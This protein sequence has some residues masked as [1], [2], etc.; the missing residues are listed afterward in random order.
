MKCNNYQKLCWLKC[1]DRLSSAMP[2]SPNSNKAV[3]RRGLCQMKGWGSG[4]GR[5]DI[6]AN[7]ALKWRSTYIHT[8][9]YTVH[10]YLHL[11]SKFSTLFLHP[12]PSSSICIYILLLHAA[13]SYFSICICNPHLHLTSRVKFS[14]PN[15]RER[16][17]RH[18]A[19]SLSRSTGAGTLS[20]IRTVIMNLTGRQV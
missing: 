10:L 3:A 5:L 12:T 2:H 6:A 17:W 4:E 7:L 13:H 19:S 16:W 14:K 11:T 18:L 15:P 1:L 20:R 8:Y 9:I